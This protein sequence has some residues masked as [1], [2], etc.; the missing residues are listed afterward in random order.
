MV[1]GWRE[2]GGEV[3]CFSES[4]GNKTP[5]GGMFTGLVHVGETSQCYYFYEDGTM[6]R[7]VWIDTGT[8]GTIY[9]GSDGIGTLG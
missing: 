7:D 4:N 9:F 8:D 3:Y 1:T 5:M 2:I 6:A